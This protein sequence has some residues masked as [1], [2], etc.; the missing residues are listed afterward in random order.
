[1]LSTTYHACLLGLAWTG[2]LISDC[3]NWVWFTN[4]E[5]N[6]RSIRMAL[7]DNC[8]ACDKI[9]THV[10]KMAVCDQCLSNGEFK[11]VRCNLFSDFLFVHLDRISRWW[12]FPKAANESE[13]TYKRLFIFPIQHTYNFGLLCSVTHSF[14]DVAITRSPM[15]LRDSFWKISTTCIYLFHVQIPGNKCTPL[16]GIQPKGKHVVSVWVT[17]QQLEILQEVSKL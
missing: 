13:N 3:W 7:S 11:S 16:E 4:I 1:M 2:H 17:G 6:W 8:W 5:T 9:F 14:T 10:W 15:C 12:E